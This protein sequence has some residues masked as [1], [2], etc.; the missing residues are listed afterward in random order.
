MCIHNRLL[1]LIYRIIFL[2]VCGIGLYLNSGI[3]NGELAPY[4]LIFY[5]IQS[6][7]LC[8]IFFSIL[9]IKNILDLKNK[10]LKGTTIFLPHFKGAVTMTIAVTFI[11]Y[12]FILAPHYLSTS[13]GYNIFS[14]QNILVHYFVPIVTI[15]DW[16]IFD[17]KS[18][19]R[20]F[21]PI[22][23]L[24]VPITYFIFILVR[25]RIGGV[26][27]IMKSQYPYFFID[28][29]VLGWINVLKN[30]GIILIGFLFLGYTIYI[31]D[32]ISVERI[33]LNFMQIKND[34]VIKAQKIG[35]HM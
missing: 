29:D 5:T 28:V 1:S 31:I 16:I 6:N 35:Y 21:N 32:K 3:A 26:I 15:L 24:I 7:V 11:I 9:I 10:G 25:A 14:W 19:F 17:E 20:W 33:A 27:L 12:H 2:F 34:L 30:A 8:F 4:M 13:S 22:Q 23:W 18:S